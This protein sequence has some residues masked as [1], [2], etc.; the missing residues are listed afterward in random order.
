MDLSKITIQTEDMTCRLCM[1]ASRTVNKDELYCQLRMEFVKPD[2]KACKKVYANFELME[3]EKK[4]K[5]AKRELIPE[6]KPEKPAIKETP[7]IYVWIGSNQETIGRLI[8][9]EARNI[10]ALERETN[11]TLDLYAKNWLW[12]GGDKTLDER[13]AGLVVSALVACPDSRYNPI[14]I[15]TLVKYIRQQFRNLKLE[16]MLKSKLKQIDLGDALKNIGG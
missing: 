6:S 15:E 14:I 12:I 11:T 8:G 9:R 5:K 3:K 4:E 2:R 16:T 10:A 7:G 13:V 1:K